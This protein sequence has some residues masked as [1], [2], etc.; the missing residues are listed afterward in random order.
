MAVQIKA[1]NAIMLTVGSR[2]CKGEMLA[3]SWDIAGQNT[4]STAN[5]GSP[6][7]FFRRGKV[8]IFQYFTTTLYMYVHIINS[9]E[10]EKLTFGGDPCAPPLNSN[11]PL[12]SS[13]HYYKIIVSNQHTRTCHTS[14]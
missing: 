12:L 8:D 2:A 11:K 5:T 10:R 6:I 14:K 4:I 3:H 1:F 9:R 7:A 13:A